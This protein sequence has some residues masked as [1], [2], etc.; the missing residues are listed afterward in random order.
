LDADGKFGWRAFC[1]GHTVDVLDD[2]TGKLNVISHVARRYD[3]DPLTEILRIGDA[4]AEHGNDF[5][6]LGE[7]LT[8]SS[9]TTSVSLDTCWNFARW[10]CNQAEATL[11]YLNAIKKENGHFTIKL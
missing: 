2:R 6:F 1:S 3:I 11:H 7:G 8:L 5:E 9:D 4:G 10:G